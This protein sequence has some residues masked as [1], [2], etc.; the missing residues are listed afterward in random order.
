MIYLQQLTLLSPEQSTVV[1]NLP[2]DKTIK[3]TC[4]EDL[5]ESRFIPI[6]KF[7]KALRE[8]SVLVRLTFD[9]ASASNYIN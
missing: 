8:A 5:H 2:V 6:G 7:V 4:L 3:I 1:H 9:V